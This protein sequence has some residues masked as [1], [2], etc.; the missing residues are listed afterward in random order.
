MGGFGPPRPKTPSVRNQARTRRGR[1]PLSG[2]QAGRAPPP[3]AAR[4]GGALRPSRSRGPPVPYPPLT[5]PSPLHPPF[6]SVPD[7]PRP[8]PP[9]RGGPPPLKSLRWRGAGGRGPRRS[10][11]PLRWRGGR[12]RVG[13]R[14]G[15]PSFP[16]TKPAPDFPPASSPFP[17]PRRIQKF[18]NKTLTPFRSASALLLLL[19]RNR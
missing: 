5:V 14:A 17:P 2:A 15:S 7:P 3:E 16:L 19:Q 11:E 18:C 10:K 1:G 12:R 13:P 6:N 8:V 4:G 9:G